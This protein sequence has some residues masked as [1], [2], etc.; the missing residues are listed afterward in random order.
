MDSAGDIYSHVRRGIKE[1]PTTKAFD[2][3]VGIGSTLRL[4][5]GVLLLLQGWGEGWG[6]KGACSISPAAAGPKL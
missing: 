6:S 4:Q 5:V 1:L 2:K 3:L